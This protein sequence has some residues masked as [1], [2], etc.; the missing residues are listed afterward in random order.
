MYS[1]YV[2]HRSDLLNN[3]GDLSHHVFVLSDPDDV[4]QAVVSMRELDADEPAA[5]LFRLRVHENGRF[6]AAHDLCADTEGPAGDGDPAVLAIPPLTGTP[7]PP[8]HPV[9]VDG[10]T[11]AYGYTA[12]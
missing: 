10:M 9:R 4:R 1:Y 3:N 5:D 12:L 2:L 6:V 11:L 7:L 8:G